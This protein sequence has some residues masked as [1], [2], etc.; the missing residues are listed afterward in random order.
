MTAVRYAEDTAQTAGRNQS[1]RSE[2][3]GTCGTDGERR[4]TYRGTVGKSEGKSHLE[5]VVIDGRMVL[6]WT[7]R[8]TDSESTLD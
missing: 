7:L 2:M 6:K 1:R 3:G 8:N 5:D 4:S